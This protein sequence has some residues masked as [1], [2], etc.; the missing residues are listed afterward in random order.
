VSEPAELKPSRDR[1]GVLEIV[2][3]IFLG[4]LSVV[5]IMQVALRYLT[6][7]PLA[8]TEEGARL[9]F[10]WSCM[11]GAAVACKRSA[12]FGVDYFTRTIRGRAGKCL[13]VGLK[14]IELAYYLVLTWSGVLITQIAVYQHLPIL[15]FSMSYAYVAL[16]IA[17][18]LM[19]VFT[20]QQAW[21][22]FR[23]EAV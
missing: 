19:C 5:V 9:L 7:Q 6:D 14:A 10:I 12:Q 13:R 23:R 11:L 20:A 3:G 16:P 4:T 1:Y 8:W 21:R 2:L 17:T 22:E 15:K 18:G